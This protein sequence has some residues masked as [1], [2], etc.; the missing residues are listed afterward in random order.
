MNNFLKGERK[1]RKIVPG[2][3]APRKTVNVK[4]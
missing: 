3:S 1:F 4:L 2:W